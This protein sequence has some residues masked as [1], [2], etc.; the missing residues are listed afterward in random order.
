ML[1]LAAWPSFIYFFHPVILCKDWQ[2]GHLAI[3]EWIEFF[4][5]LLSFRLAIVLNN[6]RRLPMK[7]NVVA[8]Q[9]DEAQVEVPINKRIL[10]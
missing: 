10:C 7:L 6:V 8:N 1:R 4:F 2:S 9:G 3:I 5:S